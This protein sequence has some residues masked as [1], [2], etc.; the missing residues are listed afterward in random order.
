MCG[1]VFLQ[2]SA[3]R[4]TTKTNCYVVVSDNP[5]SIL[6]SRIPLPEAGIPTLKKNF[7]NGIR[8]LTARS[9]IHIIR[10]MWMVGG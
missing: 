7:Q 6:R 8:L 2:F 9:L 4:R 1:M 5:N 3:A 10:A